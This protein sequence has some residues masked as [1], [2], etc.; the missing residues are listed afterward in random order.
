[1]VQFVE[2]DLGNG[3]SK[4]TILRDDESVCQIM[5]YKGDQF[6]RE[7]NKPAL[8]VYQTDANGQLYVERKDWYTDG[9]RTYSVEY[10]ISGNVHH[11]S[12]ISHWDGSFFHRAGDRPAREY[13]DTGGNTLRVEYYHHGVPV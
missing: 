1:M 12:A 10:S 13:F 6:D 2:E 11:I 4:C 9:K 7:H 3:R 8:V 5:W